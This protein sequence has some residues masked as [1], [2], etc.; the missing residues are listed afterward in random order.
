MIDSNYIIYLISDST[1]K[2]VETMI[3]SIVIQFDMEQIEKKKFTNVS[4]IDNLTDIISQ[5]KK[6]EQNVILAYT[7]ILPELCEYIEE[8]AAKYDIPIM[9]I[10]GPFMNQF[11]QILNQQ[12][13][14]EVGLSHNVDQGVVK[15]KSCMNFNIR[16]DDGK[17]LNKLTEADFV[18]IGVSR[19]YKTPLSMY[20]ARYNHKVANIS[21]SPEVEIP[22]EVYNLPSEKIIGLT[23]DPVTLQRIRQQRLKLMDVNYKISYIKL[24]RIKEELKYAQQ[25]MNKLDCQV[26][27][28]TDTSIEEIS[29]Q[30]LSMLD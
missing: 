18:L 15:R 9:D 22:Q 12:P 8:E 29:S 7:L 2:T 3:N 11:S 24:E 1:G 30:I 13:Q 27:D 23:I 16:S 6:E 28:I 20:L 19:T 17:D 14:L 10:M 4:T 5:A 21:L 26:I 25:I